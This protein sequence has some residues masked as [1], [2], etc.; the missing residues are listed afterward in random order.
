[1]K[2][3]HRKAIVWAVLLSE[4]SHVF[5]CVLPTVFSVLSLL[6]GAGMISVMPAFV[7]NMHETLHHYELP[8]IGASAAILL[9]GWGLHLYSQKIDCHDT[10]CAHGPCEGKKNKTHLL[11]MIASLLFVANVSVYALFHRSTVVQDKLY[12]KLHHGQAA[13]HAHEHAH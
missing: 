2:D 1:M 6:S 3:N 13:P 5:C 12:E 10:G 8:M 9:L 7:S 11:L 4:S